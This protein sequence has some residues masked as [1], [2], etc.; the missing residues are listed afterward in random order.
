MVIAHQQTAEVSQPGKG[1]FDL[2]P[3]AVATQRA[4]IVERR[5]APTFAMR[6]DQEHATLEQSPAQRIA[7]VAP[8]GDDAQRSLLRTAWAAPRDGDLPQRTFGQRYFAR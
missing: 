8:V 2:P 4:A 7:V 5:F 1:A 6:T 3:L